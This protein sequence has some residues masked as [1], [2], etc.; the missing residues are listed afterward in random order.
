MEAKTKIQKFKVAGFLLAAVFLAGCSTFSSSSNLTN[1]TENLKKN[2]F[3]YV[4]EIVEW[5]ELY[6]SLDYLYNNIKNIPLRYNSKKVDLKDPELKI[7]G[8]PKKEQEIHQGITVKTLNSKLKKEDKNSEN[9]PSFQMIVNTS[10]FAGKNGKWDIYAHIFSYR[11][12]VGIH[13]VENKIF[14]KSVPKYAAIAFKS[15]NKAVIFDS[16][17]SD[18]EFSD[19]HAVFGGFFTTLRDF[20]IRK[21]PQI[22]DSRTA[23]GLTQ[24]GY[25]LFVLIV[26]AERKHYSRGLSYPECSEI[27][28]KL[29]AADAIQMDGG[30]SACLFI[31]GKN[32]L[33]YSTIRKNASFIV[34]EQ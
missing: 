34:F 15:D 20:Q 24:D 31:N 29:G 18:E 25:T 21:F 7:S 5:S 17:R 26:E 13:K 2:S 1:F 27:F 4:P 10:P 8:Y 33:S 22:Q 12:I 9:K 28:L 32:Y 3:E 19:Y 23:F 30:G 6:P 11:N 16:Q 14:S